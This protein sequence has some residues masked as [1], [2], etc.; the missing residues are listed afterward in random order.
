MHLHRKEI[1]TIARKQLKSN[2]PDWKRLKK[3]VKTIKVIVNKNR[4]LNHICGKV[5]I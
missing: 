4:M 2:Y 5:N 1:K 3:G